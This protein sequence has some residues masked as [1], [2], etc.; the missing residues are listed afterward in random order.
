MFSLV[1]FDPQQEKM[2]KMEEEMMTFSDLEGLRREAEQKRRQ[3]EE[4]REELQGRREG[5][6]NNMREAQQQYEAV[7]VGPLAAFSSL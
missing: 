6:L 2:S 5:V 7:K 1:T 3:L 4:E